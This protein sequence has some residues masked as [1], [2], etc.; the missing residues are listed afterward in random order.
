MILKTNA[1]ANIE[2]LIANGHTQAELAECAGISRVQMNRILNG[3]SKPEIDTCEALAVAFGF[4][5]IA[6]LLSPLE[7]SRMVR[8]NLVTSS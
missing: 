4:P 2:S 3:H 1:V 6:L 7:F 5:P 8:K